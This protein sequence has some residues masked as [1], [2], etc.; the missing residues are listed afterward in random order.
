MKDEPT[1]GVSAMPN[2]PRVAE[3]KDTELGLE[4]QSLKRKEV[5]S[6]GGNR[7]KIVS[8]LVIAMKRFQGVPFICVVQRSGSVV[9]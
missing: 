4:R 1:R 5:E 6:S 2:T 8:Q 7:F 9:D 3:V